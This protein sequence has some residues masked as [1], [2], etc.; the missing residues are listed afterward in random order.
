MA[1]SKQGLLTAINDESYNTDLLMGQK[2]DPDDRDSV[3]N[4]P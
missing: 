3:E 1:S 2:S 4:E